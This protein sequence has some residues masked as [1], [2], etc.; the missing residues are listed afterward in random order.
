MVLSE[1]AKFLSIAFPPNVDRVPLYNRFEIQD[2]SPLLSTIDGLL[3]SLLAWPQKYFHILTA[4]EYIMLDRALL[5]KVIVFLIFRGV[6]AN[7]AG[8]DNC[9]MMTRRCL[10]QGQVGFIHAHH[11]CSER[12]KTCLSGDTSI[13]AEEKDVRPIKNIAIIGGGLAGL[14]AAYHLLDIAGNSGASASTPGMQIT[15]YDKANV[16]KGGA[17]AVA[18]G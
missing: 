7:T 10:W 18:G 11:A 5:L 13:N 17:S 12:R 1:Q 16:G 4:G 15:I 2:P 6:D 9:S 14:S 8:G 3:A